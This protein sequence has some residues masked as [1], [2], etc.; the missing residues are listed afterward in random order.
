M[1]RLERFTRRAPRN[2]GRT[3][4]MSAAALGMTAALTIQSASAFFTTYVSAGGSGTVS[5]GAQTELHEGD[6]TNMTKHIVIRNTSQTNDCFVRV[7][8]FYA[9]NFEVSYS[10]PD[11][12]TDEEAK[13]YQKDNGDGYWYYRPVLGSGESTDMLDAKIEV[14]EE[15]D[16]DSFNVVVIQECA[17]AVY[18]ADGNPDPDC[19]DM[20]FTDYTGTE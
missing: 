17:P 19:W 4:L 7:K 2:M 6:V 14:P 20:V 15:F 10:G 5:L 3:A 18:D 1:K 8:V 16:M 13:W 9:E 12:N 11:K